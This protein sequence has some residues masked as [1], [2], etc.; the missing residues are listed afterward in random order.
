M[1]LLARV[2]DLASIFNHVNDALAQQQDDGLYFSRAGY[3]TTTMSTLSPRFDLR[4]TQDAYLLDGEVPGVQ[5]K[6]VDIEF[7][8]ENTLVIKGRVAREYTNN[9]EHT[10]DTSSG[11]SSPRPATVEDATEDGE[12]IEKPSSKTTV[13]KSTAPRYKYWVKERSVGEFRRSFSFGTRV[14][15]DAVKASLRNGILSVVIP[16]APRQGARKI[17]IE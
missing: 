6:D 3:P 16:K 17:A 9:N 10:D 12:L 5:Q 1:S 11:A 15:Q 13:S 14:N 4:E 7:A 2:D 8:D